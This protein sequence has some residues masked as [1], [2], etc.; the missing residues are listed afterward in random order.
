MRAMIITL[1]GVDRSGKS[2]QAAMLVEWMRGLGYETRLFKF[3]DYSTP[4]GRL[5]AGHLKSGRADPK[6]LH[7]LMAENRQERLGDIRRAMSEAHVLVMDRY[8]ESN[9]AYGL[10]NGLDRRWLAR[11]DKGM[12]KS[13]AVILLE[14]DAAK[15]FGRRA[16]GDSFESDRPFMERVAEAYRRE[17]RTRR[18]CVVLGGLDPPVVHNAVM[19]CAVQ[20]ISE[21]LRRGRW[22]DIRPSPE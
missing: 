21:A 16:D 17:A 1:E 11:L 7:A 20:A 13:D 12:P 2:T 5:I 9:M 8:V 19:A 10:A 18:W 14:M 4:A 6:T 3:P 15:A 22:P